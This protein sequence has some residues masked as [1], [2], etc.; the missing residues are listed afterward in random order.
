MVETIASGVATRGIDDCW[1][2]IGVTGDGSC[3]LLATHIHCRNCPTYSAA[4]TALLDQLPAV[5][6]SFDATPRTR[7]TAT[8]GEQ[9][10][11]C[12]IFRVHEQWLALP[13]AALTEVCPRSPTHSL[14][15][16]RHPAVLGLASVR[17]SLL[18]C[19][20]LPALLKLPSASG[21]SHAEGMHAYADE[22]SV[23][24]SAR[25]SGDVDAH[26]ER[27]LIIGTGR[28]A[29]ALPV[30]EAAA[31]ERVPTSALLPLPASLSRTAGHLSR[32]VFFR[33]QQHVG[34]LDPQALHG[35]IAK[36]L[37]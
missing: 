12:L 3:A 24:T 16:Q 15:H 29:I 23:S 36:A 34:L 10:L 31:V 37:A 7:A 28:N 5:V 35:A 26:Q 32:A 30:N 20:S 17:G 27:L 21:G 8:S 18:V 22:N 14:P 2:R 25:M 11:S 6:Q 4:A 33:K 13:T 1:R 9:G 19:L